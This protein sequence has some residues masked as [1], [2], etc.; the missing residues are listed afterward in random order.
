ML[1]TAFH[2]VGALARDARYLYAAT[3][4]GLTRYDFTRGVW[5][6]PSTEEDGY[7]VNEQP[8][9]LAVDGLQADVWLGTA[10]GSVFRYRE[11]PAGWEN[12]GFA[13]S[14]EI[15]AIVPSIGTEEEGIWVQAGSTW[16]RANRL[17]AGVRP[18]PPA[19]VPASIVRRAASLRTLDPTLAAFRSSIGLDRRAR[20]WPITAFQRGDRPE[21]YWFATNGAFVFRFDALRNQSEWLWYG[22]A[23]RGVSALAMVGDTLWLGADGRGQRSGA[24]RTTRDLQG[25]QL[26]D[27]LEGG[28]NGRIEQ[29]VATNT[30]VYF[31]GADGV[32]RLQHGST[33]VER[34]SRE[35]ANTVAVA[36]ESV[37][38]GGRSGLLQLAGS[39]QQPALHV[40]IGRIRV[41][42][43]QIW[44]AAADG[45]YHV[46]RAVHADSLRL[47][48]ETGLPAASFVDVAS[49]GDRQIALTSDAVFLHDAAGWRG[50]VRLPAMRGLGRLTALASDGDAVWIGGVNGLVRYQ[51]ATEEWLYFLVPHDLP[52]GPV[53][54]V[55]DHEHVWLATPSG[56]LRLT[57]KRS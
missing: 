52:A 28:P 5:E 12:V 38:I 21:Q 7:P 56:A 4:G 42:G 43:E 10:S 51:P 19:N 39:R 25:W 24:V 40:G 26:R 29:I 57:W 49:I 6:L 31:A 3:R 8:S 18:V 14:G 1:I 30:H 32:S 15:A 9:A 20:R 27:A 23:T 33:R 22:A 54:I 41:L 16:F 46:A 48:R 45:L 35:R 53:D 34:L 44:F 11:V 13:L 50:P 55:P 47:V 37:W 17:G 36:G 2:E